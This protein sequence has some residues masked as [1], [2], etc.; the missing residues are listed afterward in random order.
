MAEKNEPNEQA[1]EQ[2]EDKAG[3][4]LRKE[5]VTRRITVETIAKDLK[6]NVSYIKALEANQYDALPADPYVRVYLR[7]IANYLM[8]NPDEILKRFYRDR[9]ITPEE[10][11]SEREEKISVSLNSPE[12]GG[13]GRWVLILILVLILAALGLYAYRSGWIVPEGFESPETEL[14]Q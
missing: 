4:I 3:D 13:G 14:I 5:R 9:G 2:Y 7:S 6:L 8:L 11:R 10:S 1:K 12:S